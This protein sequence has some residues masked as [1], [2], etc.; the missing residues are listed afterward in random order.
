M[1]NNNKNNVKRKKLALVSVSDK[2]YLLDMVKFLPE[3]GYEIIST[4]GTAKALQDAGV[5][6]TPISELTGFPEIMDGRVKTLH[7]KVHGGLLGLRD[8]PSHKADAE[9]NEIKW[10]DLVIVNLYPFE[11]TVAKE[12]VAIEEAIENIDIGGPSMIRSASKNYK[13]VTVLTDP[14]DYRKVLEELNIRGETSIETRERLAVKAFSYTAR[15]DSAINSYLSLKLL[16]QP[17]LNLSFENGETLRYG[18]NSHQTAVFYKMNVNETTLGSAKKLHGKEL[19]Y[20]N[21]VDGDAALESIRDLAG[22]FGVS[23][24]KHTNPCGYATGPTLHEAFERAWSGDTVSAFGSVIAVSKNVD[25]KTAR[26]LEGRFVEILI[27]PDFDSDALE[28]LKN[29]SKDIRLLKLNGEIQPPKTSKIYRHVIGGMLEQ[30]RDTLLHEKMDVVTKAPF[31]SSKIS[32]ADFAY[33]ACKHI[34]SNAI[35]LT[36]EYKPGFYMVLGM[37]AGQ[38]NR[39]DSLKKLCATKAAENIKTMFEKDK[40]GIS[41]DEF[42]KKIFGDCVMASDAFFPFSDSIASAAELDIKYI[43]QP[44]GSKRDSDV[45]AA[46]NEHGIAMIFTNTRHFKH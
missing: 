44:G 15:Y 14:A 34:K 13:H 39:V 11:K 28:F 6:V 40:P 12:G 30:D 2:T 18:E 4:G 42:K 20:N 26:C 35:V 8:N 25:I 41:Y 17:R 3:L 9:K 24:I 23:I 33:K 19:S 16:N 37:G 31:P 43:V 36:Y 38:P 1:T 45:I 27:A 10:I 29:K 7:P 22:S 21:I 5:P 46:C 32:L